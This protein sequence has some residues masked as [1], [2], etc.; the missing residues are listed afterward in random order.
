M[1]WDR[2]VDLNDSRVQKVLLK[3]GLRIGRLM[4]TIPTMVSRTPLV[5]S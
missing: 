1:P 5:R 2:V 3:R 4:V